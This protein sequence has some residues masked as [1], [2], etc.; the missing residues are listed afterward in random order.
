MELGDHGVRT[1][2]HPRCTAP[3]TLLS[4]RPP[5]LILSR[6]D[7]VLDRYEARDSIIEASWDVQSIIQDV[8]LPSIQITEKLELAL[9]LRIGVEYRRFHSYYFRCGRTPRLK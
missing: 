7:R 3:S 1:C 6:S 9:C 2:P 5:L 8:K 4:C